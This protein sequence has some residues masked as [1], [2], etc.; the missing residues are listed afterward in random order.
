MSREVRSTVGQL[1]THLPENKVEVAWHFALKYAMRGRPRPIFAHI[2]FEVVREHGPAKKSVAAAREGRVGRSPAPRVRRDAWSCRT[3]RSLHDS[4]DR[5]H[6]VLVM[7]SY[8]IG[9]P[10]GKGGGGGEAEPMRAAT[11]AK[12][13]GLHTIWQRTTFGDTP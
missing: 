8:S 6:N 7:A 13:R 9:W 2:V 5:A 1:P 12:D 3:R 10:G 4:M 11:P